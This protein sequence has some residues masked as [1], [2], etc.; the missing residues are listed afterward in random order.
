[1]ATPLPNAASATVTDLQSGD[2]GILGWKPVGPNNVPQA[3]QFTVETLAQAIPAIYDVLVQGS[4]TTLDATPTLLSGLPVMA[5]QRC[6]NILTGQV[7]AQNTATG[8]S[9][10]WDVVVNLKRTAAN[11]SPA[12][13]GGSSLPVTIR[14]QDS[15]MATCSLAITL[16][17]TGPA[18][19]ATGIVATSIEWAY[20]FTVV[21]AD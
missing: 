16:S 6:I 11:T 2:V 7:T 12:F 13:I 17:S 5:N 18:I 15:N 21:T 14:C 4:I 10:V 8:D 19:T 9:S 1:M 20:T 3:V